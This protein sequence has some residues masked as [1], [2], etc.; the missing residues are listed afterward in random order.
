MG[1]KVRGGSC[2]FQGGACGA[3]LHAF[4]CVRACGC[5]ERK[6][7]GV[8]CGGVSLAGL[9]RPSAVAVLVSTRAFNGICMYMYVY[10]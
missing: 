8:C 1:R 7:R 4:L 9:N 5:G 2:G 10:S 3:F 6:G